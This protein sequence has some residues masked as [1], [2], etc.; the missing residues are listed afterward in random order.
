MAT[1]RTLAIIKPDGVEKKVVGKIIDRILEEGL[2]P[3]AMRMQHLSKREAEGFYAV[4]KERPFFAD[5][6]TFMTRGP[7]VLMILEGED[8]IARW[9]GIMG[10]T[11]P[12]N[13]DEGTLRKLYASNIEENTVHGS[14][15]VETAAFETG[16]FFRGLEVHQ[17]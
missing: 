10:A 9:R 15:A 16:W 12:E 13:A 8:A 3:V 6:V 17:G 14:D 7:V 1:E 5:L 11:N 4:H 2:T